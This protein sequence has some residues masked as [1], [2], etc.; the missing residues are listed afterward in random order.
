MKNT[1]L[2]I[3]TFE[4]PDKDAAAIRV[5]GI[6]MALTNAGYQVVL[7][8]RNK[9]E[10]LEYHKFYSFQYKDRPRWSKT[11]YY[12][13]IQY[14]IDT[15]NEIGVDKVVAIIAYH[16]PA[17][18][19]MKLLKHCNK[20]GI[21]LISDNT[22]WYQYKLLMSG[23]NR[24]L[25]YANFLLR[26]KWANI[27]VKNIIAISSFLYD[28]YQSRNCNVERVPILSFEN[29]N[30]RL[31]SRTW[32]SIRLV[33]C[34]SPAKKD[35]LLPLVQAVSSLSREYDIELRLVGISRDQFETF[36]NYRIPEA[37]NDNIIFYGRVP[38]KQAV[39]I[40]QKNDFSI[41]IRPEER[42]A[43]AGFPTK[44]VEAFSNG[45]GVIATPVGD[46]REYVID[47][48][49]GFLLNNDA[50]ESLEALLK[51][52]CSMTS[53]E[54]TQIKENS[55]NLSLEKFDYKK[56]SDSLKSFIERCK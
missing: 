53:Q 25:E 55:Y 10:I 2:I 45:L 56:Y 43:I 33:Y 41:I 26:M 32:N 20:S 1:V 14:V 48:K 51:R 52:I 8:G 27:K 42:Y 3:G 7:Q 17:I 11:G 23:G 47:G 19:M 15:I 44:M 35:S 38:H 6:A 12:S 5:T 39:R 50:K 28:Y 46:L 18:A 49:T 13:D 40:L 54:L 37:N 31:L 36:Y 9:A 29:S 21:K 16:Y 4:M 22:E 30:N 34:G 24:E